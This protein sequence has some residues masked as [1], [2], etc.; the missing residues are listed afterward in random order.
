MS[1]Q[2]EIQID[3]KKITP[4][5]KPRVIILPKKDVDQSWTLVDIVKQRAPVGW[6]NLFAKLGPA[7]KHVES[8]IYN[9]DYV[10][11]KC[12]IFNAYHYTPLK[13][14]KVIIIGQ[15]PYYTSF[16]GKPQAMGL[17]FSCRKGTPIQP[18][19]KNIYKELLSSVE[20]FEVPDHGDLTGWAKQGVLLLNTSLT[21]IEGL[22]NA[23]EQIWFGVIQKTLKEVVENRPNTVVILWGGHAEKVRPF[24]GNLKSLSSSHPSPMSANRGFFGCNHFNLANEYLI[25][26]NE[27][28]INWNYLP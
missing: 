25:S 16:N 17:S 1:D 28:P 22:A 3:E 24:I 27:T 21:T 13:L 14:V 26:K 6:K 7:V 11:L 9:D 12:D 20:G 10:P 15:D 18:S 8:Q 19:L 5:K 23:H 4:K 2:D